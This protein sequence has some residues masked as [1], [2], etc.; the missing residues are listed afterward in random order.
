MAEDGPGKALAAITLSTIEAEPSGS[1][2]ESCIPRRI[3]PAPSP[4]HPPRHPFAA[5]EAFL[6][7][8]YADPSKARDRSLVLL[9]VI[10]FLGY[11]GWS[12][13]ADANGLD[14]LPP[15]QTQYFLAGS[16][17][18]G[19]SGGLYLTMRYISTIRPILE[20]QSTL[21]F[22]ILLIICTVIFFGLVALPQSIVSSYPYSLRMIGLYVWLVAFALD[23]ELVSFRFSK[24]TGANDVFIR[25]V[26]RSMIVF[27]AAV[28]A[29]LAVLR[30]V[31]SG[32]GQIPQ[33]L[34]G[35]RPR[36]ATLELSR[37]KISPETL[38]TLLPPATATATPTPDATPGSVSPVDGT[39]KTSRSVE[40]NVHFQSSDLLIVRPF[41]S[42]TPR[43]P[44][45]AGN[46]PAA[47]AES[48]GTPIPS[49]RGHTYEIKRSAVEAVT[50]CD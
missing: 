32:Y 35:A 47:L 11:I 26:I 30:F 7:D 2:A 20:K 25:T 48:T 13:Y 16:V 23:W 42:P 19:I 45:T 29:M 10:Y 50:W 37:E 9:A 41:A 36:C 4:P 5:F 6:R 49:R 43:P 21:V 3:T 22:W 18:L 17:I 28:V 15:L 14:P 40:V 44:S 12:I 8:A 24:L 34:G 38:Q 46:A 1:S 39:V 31:L 27:F 33:A